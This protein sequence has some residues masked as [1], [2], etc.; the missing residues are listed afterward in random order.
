VWHDWTYIGLLA[1]Q[2]VCITVAI[3]APIMALY[4]LTRRK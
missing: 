2:A 1:L 3:W 4:L